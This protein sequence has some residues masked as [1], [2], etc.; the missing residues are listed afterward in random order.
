MKALRAMILVAV[1]T[2]LVACPRQEGLPEA[3]FTVTPE[4]GKK[5]LAVTFTDTSLPG[6][7][8]ITAW[9]WNFGDDDT[10]TEQNPVHTYTANGTYDVKLT[11]TNTQGSNA[12][13][14]TGAVTVGN[15][16]AKTDG[17]SGDD[18][19]AS[20][21]VA[22]NGD[23]YIVST[24]TQP[25]AD[26]TD[27]Q[28]QRRNASGET[29]GTYFFGGDEDETA[30]AVIFSD[31]EL[32][33]GGTTES[34]GVGGEDAYVLRVDTVGQEI[35]AETFGTFSDDTIE[36]GVTVD[37]G[38]V[39]VGQTSP[40]GQVSPNVY[41]LKVDGDGELVWSKSYGTSSREVGH[42]VRVTSDGGFII[43]GEQVKTNADMFVVRADKDGKELWSGAYGGEGAG[44]ERAFEPFASGD[45][46]VILGTGYSETI[47]GYDVMILKLDKDG[48]KVS[49][50]FA[51][52]LNREDGFSAIA[53]GSN[54]IVAG[55]TTTATEGKE[56][57]YLLSVK[58]DGTENWAHS[59]GGL[60]KDVASDIVASDGDFVIVGNTASWGEGGTDGYL[61]RTNSLG[62]GPQVPTP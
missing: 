46:F 7:S 53:V 23:L 37:G 2:G 4:Y 31:D 16:W 60:E 11:V 22:G 32:I 38:F 26:N 3:S 57:V 20:V 21:A 49:T 45:G 62:N 44:S 34:F 24:V 55:S 1:A 47:T 36:S 58:A 35:W 19:A 14:K 40:T 17:F 52:G 51:G 56:D 33:I 25:G 18:R 39:F 12:T 41:L 43:A 9:A 10:S 5:P 61:L 30:G 29:I 8:P 15:V 27:I 28:L 13:I 48:K 54:F 6:D 50:A 59:F 42:G